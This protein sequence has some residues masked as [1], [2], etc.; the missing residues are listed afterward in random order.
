MRW[1][2]SW[3][4]PCHLKEFFPT[5]PS[6]YFSWNTTSSGKPFLGEKSQST[7]EKNTPFRFYKE[8]TPPGRILPPTPPPNQTA[9]PHSGGSVNP[10]SALSFQAKQQNKPRPLFLILLILT[11]HHPSHHLLIL[12]G[13]FWGNTLGPKENSRTKCPLA[14]SRSLIPFSSIMALPKLTKVFRIPTEATDCLLVLEG[15]LLALEAWEALEDR[16]LPKQW[17][18]SVGDNQKTMCFFFRTQGDLSDWNCL[19]GSWWMNWLMMLLIWIFILS[20]LL[21]GRILGWSFSPPKKKKKTG[22]PLGSKDGRQFWRKSAGRCGSTL[23]LP[24]YSSIQRHWKDGNI[25]AVS[26]MIKNSNPLPTLLGGSSQD[27]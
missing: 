16:W 20:S 14:R 13:L 6:K 17:Q 10:N 3:N 15:R 26:W 23:S 7:Q 19:L 2:L 25:Q 27:L 11:L 18:W 9:K 5:T 4:K 22:V 24:T 12:L 8:K 1:S 21:V